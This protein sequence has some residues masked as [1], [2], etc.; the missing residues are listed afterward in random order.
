[1]VSCLEWSR[2]SDGSRDRGKNDIMQIWYGTND[3]PVRFTDGD[4]NPIT[5]D[6]IS[7]N[8][9][10]VAVDN[11]QRSTEILSFEVDANPEEVQT[12]TF[13]VCDGGAIGSKLLTTG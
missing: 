13:V 8:A 9:L 1:M 5:Q 2:N 11:Y 3:N 10:D 7:D 12:L 4:G 6:I